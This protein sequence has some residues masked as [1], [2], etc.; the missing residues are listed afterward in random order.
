MYI[1][2]IAEETLFIFNFSFKLE[3]RSE[4]FKIFLSSSRPQHLIQ[5]R[6]EDLTCPCVILLG[7]SSLN[8]FINYNNIYVFTKRN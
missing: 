5:G 1:L 2:K 6:I 7:A 3:N 8:I 4:I